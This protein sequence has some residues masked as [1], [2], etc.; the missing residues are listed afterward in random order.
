MI[1]IL[2]VVAVAVATTLLLMKFATPKTFRALNK[3]FAIFS[4]KH[5]WV[6]TWLYD[7]VR[8]IH[9]LCIGFSETVGRHLRHQN[10]WAGD[11]NYVWIGVAVG[12]LV[13][14]HRRLAVG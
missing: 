5:N 8:L 10:Q 2:L 3:Q 11:A 9:Q 1:R 6:M 13:R 4:N 12:A 14:A 7:D